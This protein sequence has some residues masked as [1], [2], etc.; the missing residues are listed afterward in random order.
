MTHSDSSSCR[1]RIWD[2]QG[3]HQKGQRTESYVSSRGLRGRRDSEIE[4]LRNGIKVDQTGP[5]L[6]HTSLREC[7]LS[8]KLRPVPSPP[9]LSAVTAYWRHNN[10]SIICAKWFGWL[11]LLPND[12]TSAP[13]LETWG[14]SA[15]AFLLQWN[16]SNNKS[17]FGWIKIKVQTTQS[18]SQ[19]KRDKKKWRARL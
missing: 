12:A 10:D 1:T 14:A 11:I 7:Y 13:L 18:R 6:W 8:R 4:I 5:K 3:K 9:S 17:V 19:S 16:R 2:L 15:A